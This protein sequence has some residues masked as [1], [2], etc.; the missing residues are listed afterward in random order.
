[1]TP[2]DLSTAE[3]LQYASIPVVAALI[4][5]IT[6]WLA[7]KLTFKPLEFVGIPPFLGW[8]GI[9]P[10]KARKMADLCVDATIA[11]LGTVQEIFEQIDPELLSQH[12]IDSLM[13]RVEEYVDD[14]MTREHR[15]LWENLPMRARKIV[16][17]RVRKSA[18]SLVDK[19][20]TDIGL[21]IDTLLDLKKLVADCLEADRELLNRLFQEC[22]EAEFRF[23]INS[24][25]VFGFIFGL[26]QMVAWY[27]Y[28]SSWVL[29]VCGFIVGWATNWI[30]LNIIFRPVRPTKIGPFVIQGLFLKRQPEVAN[31]FCDIVT[32]EILTVGN[33]LNFMLNGPQSGHMRAIIRKHVKPLVDETA[34]ITKPLTQIAFGPSGFAKLREQVGEHAIM[35]SHETFDD[36][37]FNKS[38][39]T[40]VAAIMRERMMLL[41]PEEFQALLRPCFQEDEVKLIM[42][43]G[44]LGMLAGVAQ[45]IWVFGESML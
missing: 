14:V 18:P 43:G 17:D 4:G 10:S 20:V 45:L 2:A 24:G 30:A 34:G 28:P 12:V 27:F 38:R 39:A 36:P 26:F 9:I 11:K 33:I 1:M 7:V 25:F 44:V 42:I 22:G 32:Q 31:V 19:L 13:P 16:Y 29:P 6:N 8:Q 37:L 41:S 3:L 35:L 21:Q 23:I 40:A 15:T 5:W